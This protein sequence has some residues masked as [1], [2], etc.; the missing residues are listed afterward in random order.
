MHQYERVAQEDVAI[1]VLTE[2]IILLSAQ[3]I[4]YFRPKK[5][6]RYYFLI[7]LYYNTKRE[8]Y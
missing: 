8:I 1:N 4:S 2:S 3:D 6:Y 7:C 5:G